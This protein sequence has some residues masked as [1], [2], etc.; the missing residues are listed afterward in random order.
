MDAITAPAPAD[1]LYQAPFRDASSAIIWAMA[2]RTRK[3]V[4]GS[5]GINAGDILRHLDVLYRKKKITLMQGRIIRIYG[6]RGLPPDDEFPIDRPQWEAAM[7]ALDR[8]LRAAG[9]VS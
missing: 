6:E 9:I 1:S 2:T 4:A 5:S 7:A 3:V 8:P